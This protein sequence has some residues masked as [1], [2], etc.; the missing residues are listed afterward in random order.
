LLALLL[1]GCATSPKAKHDRALARAKELV[2]KKDYA[3][4]L[5]ECRTAVKMM[6]KDPEA[7]YQL[8]VVYARSHE[9][10]NAVFSFN[11][12]LQLKPDFEAAQ[13]EIAKLMASTA[14]R[15]T[16]KTAESR[17]AEVVKNDPNNADALSTLGLAELKLGDTDAAIPELQR[18]LTVAPKSLQTSVLLAQ[19]KLS[20]SDVSGAEQVL[21]KACQN[22]PSSAEPRVALASFYMG[23]KQ[24]SDAERTLLEATKID[25]TSGTALLAL[26]RLQFSQG[27]KAEAEETFRRLSLLP[28]K[29]LAP[30]YAMFL[31]QNGH[32]DKAMGE[33][34]RL[35]HADPNDRAARSRLVAAYWSTG[36]TRE[37]EAVL[38]QALSKNPN[39]SEALLQRAEMSIRNAK[40]PA[41]EA[42]LNTILH[43]NSGSAEAHYLLSKVYRGE[44]DL[45]RQR[46]EL[47]EALRLKPAALPL[48]LEMASLLVQTN[49]AASA[50]QVLD[51]TPAFEKNAAAV[52][53]ERNWALMASGDL[54]GARRG[55]DA[56][57]AQKRLPEAVLQDGVWK[58][59]EHQTAAG[60]ADLEEVLSANPTELRALNVLY[61]SYAI[62]HQS[63]AGFQKIRDYASKAPHSVPV[64][65]FLAA[66][67][68]ANGSNADARAALNTVLSIDPHSRAA[69]VRMEQLDFKEHKFDA[70]AAR[71]RELLKTNPNDTDAH[72]LLANVEEA[73]G[74]HADALGEYQKVVDEDPKN[75]EALNNLAYLLVDFKKQPDA[76]LP[77]AQ[78]AQQLAPNDPNYE[79]TVGWVFYQKGL[80]AL[81][82]KSFEAAA[83]SASAAPVCK[84]HLAMAYAKLG[85][86]DRGR[87]VLATALKQAPGLPEAS[88]A[89]QLLAQ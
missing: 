73:S 34:E 5:L 38:A 72:L 89:T 4:A 55:I 79:D 58:I 84:Y 52:A 53:L 20:R 3:R 61:A 21:Q 37:A 60:R 2:Q 45:L 11:K 39:D 85:N 6:P 26:G 77:Y 68:A 30:L 18:A 83:S 32:P 44:G 10:Q 86:R 23:R 8:G 64:Q 35:A 9:L 76:A 87:T 14:E 1:F 7:Y 48:R 47:G 19:A 41:A 62:D 69:Q 46:Q 80:Y 88:A 70:A 13:V 29:S 31:M 74:D 43:L 28:D 22:D 50:L 57:L 16:V 56:V 71:L 36:R 67:C 63:A 42:D 33:F 82:A 65:L 51:A 40:Y 54:K 15:D 17:M 24:L 78:K 49:G 27:Q 59:H 81:A 25:P 75:A 12:G 66:V